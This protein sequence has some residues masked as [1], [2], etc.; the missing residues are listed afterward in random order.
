[1]GI[2][3]RSLEGGAKQSPETPCEH[4]LPALVQA[5]ASVFHT[6]FPMTP[7]SLPAK[8]LWEDAVLEAN[9]GLTLGVGTGPASQS[10][11]S[12]SPECVAV[13]GPRTCG[14]GDDLDI[15]DLVHQRTLEVYDFVL[16]QLPGVWKWWCF[17]VRAA[18]DVS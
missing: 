1:M 4:F 17:W 12:Q 3:W 7:Q 10:S 8:G 9:L 15:R 14:C 16:E 13:Q 18:E 5:M 11:R 6:T 2:R